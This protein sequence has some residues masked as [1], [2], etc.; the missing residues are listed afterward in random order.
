MVPD[1]FIRI[2]LAGRES[3]FNTKIASHSHPQEATNASSGHRP[4]L[5]CPGPS[6]RSRAIFRVL[7]FIQNETGNEM[8]WPKVQDLML[9]DCMRAKPRISRHIVLTG[10]FARSRPRPC[11]PID[12]HL[13]L[14][15]T[16]SIQATNRVVKKT[17]KN[18]AKM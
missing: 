7:T 12:R 15:N 8:L 10:Y 14:A 1:D 5:A 4:G 11:A 18:I 6:G 16:P 2:V 9:V 13:F 17:G 3:P